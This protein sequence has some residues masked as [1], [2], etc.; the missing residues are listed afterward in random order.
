MKIGSFEYEIGKISA[1]E[2]LHLVRKLS[3]SLSM[4]EGLIADRNAGKDMR[5]LTVLMLSN[6]SD[7]DS[8]YVTNKCLWAVTMKQANG[9]SARIMSAGGLM[10]QHIDLN[11]ILELT[12]EVILENL[13]DFFKDALSSLV[14]GATKKS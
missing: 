4:M 10:F 14:A 11:V 8:E 3:R 9:Q 6:L 13:G 1:M 5:L 2:Q 7:E 12:V